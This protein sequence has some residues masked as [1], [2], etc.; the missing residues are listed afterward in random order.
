MASHS[1]HRV[2]IQ[3]LCSDV[4]ADVIGQ[5]MVADGSQGVW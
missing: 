2:A 3:F 4:S 5:N 1:E